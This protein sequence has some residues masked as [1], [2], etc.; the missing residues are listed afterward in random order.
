MALLSVGS[1]GSEVRRVQEALVKSGHLSGPVDGEFG[2]MTHEAVRSFQQANRLKVDGK[3]GDQTLA[4][5][6]RAQSDFQ[7]VG[8][9]STQAIRRVPGFSTQQLSY[10]KEM[11]AAAKAAGIP[12]ELPVMTALVE[13]R[14]RNLPHGDR[15]SVG[16]FQ[17]R[18]AWGSHA[19]RMNVAKSTHM[20][21]HG[22]RAGQP[23]AVD[24][25]RMFG[26]LPPTAHNLGRWAQKVQVS[27]FP[28]RYAEEYATARRL[29]AAV[30]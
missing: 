30:A 18:N 2:A 28:H 4:A 12:P 23:G 7:P 26:S 10:V 13:T 1:Q 24:Y 27:A 9:G 25:K 5:L 16:L 21:L 19:D 8:G 3:V 6:R 22:G 14:L 15:D 20:F 29:L 11:A 17:Q